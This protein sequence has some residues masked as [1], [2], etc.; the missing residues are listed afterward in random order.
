MQI[1][2]GNVQIGVQGK[3]RHLRQRTSLRQAVRTHDDR[4]L[5]QQLRRRGIPE[6]AVLQ[7]FIAV[8]AAI[9][10]AASYAERGR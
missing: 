5:L 6:K 8:K 1:T 9:L 7:R 4:R 10:T 2:Y 3:I